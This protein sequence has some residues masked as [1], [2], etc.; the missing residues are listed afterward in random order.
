MSC[1]GRQVSEVVGDSTRPRL[2]ASMATAR[3]SPAANLLRHSR[4]F[5]IPAPL[6]PPIALVSDTAS[7]AYPTRA[8]IETPA[9]SWDRGDWGF[10]RS[11]PL[12]STSKTGTTTI[13]VQ[14]GIDSIEHIT[15]F[16]SAADHVLTLQKW[17][18]INL[19]VRF[20]SKSTK[21]E[22]TSV[23]EAKLDNI[24]PSTSPT[25]RRWRYSG[26]WLAGQPGWEFDTLLKNVGARKT[27]FQNYVRARLTAERNLSKRQ[28][29]ID[30]GVDLD[31]VAVDI[32]EEE[33]SEH[34]RYLRATPSAFGPLIVDFLDLPDGPRATDETTAARAGFSYGRTTVAAQIYSERGPPRTHPSAGLS[35]FRSGAHVSN[36]AAFGPQENNP[37]V[38]ARVLK[39]SIRRKQGN[40][41]IAGFVASDSTTSAV[42]GTSKGAWQPTPG[43]LKVLVRPTTAT[44]TSDGR[45]ILSAVPAGRNTERMYGFKQEEDR[46]AVTKTRMASMPTLD[47]QRA[48]DAKASRE[49]KL[50]LDALENMMRLNED[51]E[52]I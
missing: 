15:D 10:K 19:P 23:F 6:T 28:E 3:I 20:T 33:F 31:K 37:P 41:G 11:L 13:R 29:A 46:L 12:K 34:M 8:A 40:V 35:Y 22:N 7:Q 5:S 44:V 32:S 16:E 1:T 30:A 49:T 26:P 36:H 48:T 45:L 21:D 4:L 24:I 51:R 17:R 27:E 47:E 43:G 38:V 2:Y 52:H 14:N 42:M 50:H 39:P 25:H 9:S 18:E